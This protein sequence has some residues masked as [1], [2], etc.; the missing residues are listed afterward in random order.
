MK[1]ISLVYNLKY[2]RQNLVNFNIFG[3]F[4]NPQDQQNSKLP[5]DLHFDKDLKEKKGFKVVQSAACRHCIYTWHSGCQLTVCLQFVNF[6]QT[7]TQK[8]RRNYREDRHL[9]IYI[10]RV[11]T[12]NFILMISGPVGCPLDYSIDYSIDI[13]YRTHQGSFPI[14]HFFAWIY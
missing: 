9:S 11:S 4:R 5:L 14:F 2:F 1:L 8:N 10:Y 7:D 3:V 12:K 6:I 13:G